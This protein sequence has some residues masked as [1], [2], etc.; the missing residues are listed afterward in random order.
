[1]LSAV[2]IRDFKAFGEAIYEYGRLA[3]ECFA[4][5]QGGPYA[6]EKVAARVR[7][8]RRLGALGVGQSSWG[9]TVFAATASQESAEDLVGRLWFELDD[10][11]LSFEIAAPDN[12]GATI[13]ATECGGEC[14]LSATPLN[15]ATDYNKP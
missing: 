4:V 6:N 15:A 8:F 11:K 12:Q 5:V 14:A 9:P 1:V 10:E 3:G 7:L 13:S 2:E